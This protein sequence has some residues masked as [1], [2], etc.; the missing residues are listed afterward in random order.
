MNSPQNVRF[1]SVLA[2]LG[3]ACGLSGMSWIVG[4]FGVSGVTAQAIVKA[5]EVGSW[6]MFLVAIAATDGLVGAG[7]WGAIKLMIAKVGSKAAVA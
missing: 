6:G 7:L 2:A 4:T 3:L 1:I 5:V